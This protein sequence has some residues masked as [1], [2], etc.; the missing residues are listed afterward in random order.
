MSIVIVPSYRIAL[1]NITGQYLEKFVA[2]VHPKLFSIHMSRNGG[3]LSKLTL[4]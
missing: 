3:F 4:Q 1:Q 2:D